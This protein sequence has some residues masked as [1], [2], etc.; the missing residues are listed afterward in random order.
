MPVYP[1]CVRR[2]YIRGCIYTYIYSKNVLRFLEGASHTPVSR[3]LAYQFNVRVI[4]YTALHTPFR[5]YDIVHVRSNDKKPRSFRV[6]CTLVYT[7]SL[8]IRVCWVTLYTGIEFTTFVFVVTER[9]TIP[10]KGAYY[11][12]AYSD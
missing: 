3:A 9:Y 7:T 5:S 1:T 11:I 12:N 8:P 10:W 4:N 2:V 6:K